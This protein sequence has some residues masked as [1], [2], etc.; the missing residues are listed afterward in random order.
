MFTKTRLLAGIALLVAGS[1]HA[2]PDLTQ[3]APAVAIPGQHEAPAPT[4]R[5]V[6]AD[7]SSVTPPEDAVRASRSDGG[8]VDRTRSDCD[9]N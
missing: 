1:A 3:A 8:T 5:A 2:A 4:A 9:G 6:A 7:V